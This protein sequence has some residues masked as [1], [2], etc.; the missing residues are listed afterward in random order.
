[1]PALAPEWQHPFVNVFKLCD[2]DS[3]KEFETKGDVTE[4]MDK[5]IGKKVFKVRGVVPAGNYLRVPRTKLQSL[6]LTGRFLYI[7][8]KVT[9]VKVFVIH[10]EVI[11]E[12]NNLHRVSISNMYSADALKRKSNGVQLPFGKPSHRCSIFEMVWLPSEP[13]D[14]PTMDFL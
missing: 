9:P 6:G 1:M 11:T 7:Q 4:H 8:L 3:M 2:V 13:H 10:I 12:D 5:I 14:A